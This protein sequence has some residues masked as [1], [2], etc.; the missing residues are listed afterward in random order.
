MDLVIENVSHHFS[1]VPVLNGTTLRARAGEIISLV[2]AS[3]CGKTTLLRLV[4]GLETLQ[5]GRVLLGDEPVAE[6]GR[7]T[8][9]GKRPIG[10]VFQDYVLFPNLT[11]R[12]NVGFGAKRGREAKALVSE[13]LAAFGLTD[14]ARR[15]PHELSGGQQQRVALARALVRSPKALLLDEPFASIDT[16]YRKSLGEELRR[17]L[18]KQNVAVIFVTHDPDDA[19]TLGDRIAF[20]KAGA[21]TECATTQDLFERPQTSQGAM[22]F[23]GS[24]TLQGDVR[25]GVFS[26][27]IGEVDAPDIADGPALAVL[28]KGA[29]HAS[30]S[31]T[32]SF[33]VEDCQYAGPG[34]RVTLVPRSGSAAPGQRLQAFVPVSAATG[35]A[36]EVRAD[37][38]KVFV[39]SG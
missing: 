20:M 1:G 15:Y 8:P 12:E 6:P 22:I 17:L 28:R 3:G 10:F 5:S 21:I 18:K 9:P 11:V 2:G 39:F 29:V 36:F 31:P 38:A 13:T 25:S 19:L 30:P 7:A 33:V 34:W 27:M 14:L 4:A 35:T 24:Q 26:S 32:G 16:V 23:P 37:P